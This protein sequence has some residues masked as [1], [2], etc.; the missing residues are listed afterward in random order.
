[1]AVDS[2]EQVLDLGFPSF[3]YYSGYVH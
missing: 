2:W 3:P 1:M